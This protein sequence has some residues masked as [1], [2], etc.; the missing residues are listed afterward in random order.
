VTSVAVHTQRSIAAALLL[1]I[2]GCGSQAVAPTATEGRRIGAIVTTHNMM[3]RATGRLPPNEQEF[4]KFITEKGSQMMDRAAVTGVDELFVSDRDGQPLVVTYGKYPPEMAAKIVVY[5]KS[6][7][8]GKRFVGYNS[9]A[10]ELVDDARFS[11]LVSAS[12]APK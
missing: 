11:E 5:E 3:E 9:G 4:K 12:K 10:V 6:G 1:V 8:D 7:A 2:T